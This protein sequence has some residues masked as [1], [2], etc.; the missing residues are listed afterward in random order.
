[1]HKYLSVTAIWLNEAIAEPKI[2]PLHNSSR[3]LLFDEKKPAGDV[4]QR[5]VDAIQKG[6]GTRNETRDE[7]TSALGS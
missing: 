3:H 6:R 7:A 2:K 1:M 5:A 4:H